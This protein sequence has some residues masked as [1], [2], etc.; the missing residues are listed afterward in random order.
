MRKL[1]NVFAAGSL[2]GLLNALAVWGAGALGITIQFGVHIAP[3]LTNTLIYSKM[4]W[5]GI[6][7]I[8]FLLPVFRSSIILR[9]LILSLGPTLVQL[10]YIFPHIAGKGTMGLQLGMATPLFVVLYNAIWGWTAAVWLK[11]SGD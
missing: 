6:W 5:G 4:V 10:F 1:G 7:G 3:P 11:A 2:G 8:L 9:G